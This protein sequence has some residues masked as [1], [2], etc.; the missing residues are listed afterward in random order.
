MMK[1]NLFLLL[2]AIIAIS[3]TQKEEKDVLLSGNV[4]GVEAG[5][6]YLQKFRNKSY[7]VCNDEYGRC[8]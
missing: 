5:T 6:V 2:I 3:C 7:Y 4:E 1:K 8:N